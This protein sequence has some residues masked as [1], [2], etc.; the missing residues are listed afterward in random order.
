MSKNDHILG[1]VTAIALLAIVGLGAWIGAKNEPGPD[2][3]ICY[4]P[5]ADR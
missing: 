4:V 1:F 2:T 5:G 3:P